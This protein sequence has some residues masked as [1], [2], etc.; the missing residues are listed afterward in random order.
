MPSSPPI[1]RPTRT[2]RGG[3]AGDG[4]RTPWKDGLP[5]SWCRCT[6]V[7]RRE[8]TILPL[9]SARGRVPL[10][11]PCICPDRRWKWPGLCVLC[12]VPAPAE[13]ARRA[14]GSHQQAEE[15][16]QSKSNLKGK[17]SSEKTTLR[18]HIFGGFSFHCLISPR[19]P[20]LGEINARINPRGK[21]INYYLK[22][23]TPKK[24]RQRRFKKFDIKFNQNLIKN[25]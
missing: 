2:W 3:A 18:N 13:G 10:P 9:F 19:S 12:F 17:R 23:G 5:E 7:V 22:M 4:S 1:R 21:Y 6:E 24:I 11:F 16:R 14:R 20:E 8:R 15:P 25:R